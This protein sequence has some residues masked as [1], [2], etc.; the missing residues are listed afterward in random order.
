[1]IAEQQILDFGHVGRGKNLLPQKLQ[2]NPWF[3]I[4]YLE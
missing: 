3:K 2:S 4:I 1:M